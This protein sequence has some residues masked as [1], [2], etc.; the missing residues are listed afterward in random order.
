MAEV[1]PAAE[2]QVG[3]TQKA[4]ETTELVEERAV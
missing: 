4:E 1:G 2:V 3:G